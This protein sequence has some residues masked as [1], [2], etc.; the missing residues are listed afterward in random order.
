MNNQIDNN[1][2]LAS[3]S[4]SDVDDFEKMLSDFINKEFDEGAEEA[5]EEINE[6]QAEQTEPETENLSDLV[7]QAP[8][9][10]GEHEY[11]LFRA[12]KNFMYAIS[13]LCEDNNL[14]VPTLHLT[15]S[16]LQPHY[17]KRAGTS[18][19]K[20]ILSG[21]EIMLKLFPNEVKT[22]NPNSTDDQLLD[23]AEKC[24]NENLQLAIISHVETMIELE[25][26]EIDYETR[27]LKYERKK[28]EKEIYEAHQRHLERSRRYIEAINEKQFPIN[29]EKLVNNYFR[30]SNKDPE[31]SF[32]ALTTNPATFAPIDFSKI[33][34]RFFGMIKVK[35]QDGIRINHKIGE[36]LKRLKI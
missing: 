17:K 33:K 10:L 1:D 25:G 2:V 8:S 21:W 20:D 13:M 5:Q 27:K 26:C 12:Y 36:F 23:F 18:V 11:S 3:I 15:E 4:D 9:N 6:L 30:L 22:I 16:K 32:K 31:G 34:D 24:E 19:S 28:L 14:E 35:P 29:A 7:N